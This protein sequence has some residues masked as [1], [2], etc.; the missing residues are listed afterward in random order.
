ML[1][2]SKSNVARSAIDGCATLSLSALFIFVFPVQIAFQDVVSEL[3]VRDDALRWT[4]YVLPSEDG[5][6]MAPT[7]TYA[8]VN[9][10]RSEGRLSLSGEGAAMRIA[11][12]AGE[13]SPVTEVTVGDR[14]RINRARKGDRLTTRLAGTGPGELA[15][16]SLRSMASLIVVD[17]GN[18]LP[19]VAFVKPAPLT[20][21]EPTTQ[22]AKADI[23]D[24]TPQQKPAR[25]DDKLYIARGVA[26]ASLSLV[27]AYAP[28]NSA[29]LNAPFNAL[30]GGKPK[31]GAGLGEQQDDAAAASD[32]GSSHGWVANTLPSS[33]VTNKEQKCLAEA[34]YF[35]ARG[36]PWKGQVAVAQV[37][38][39]R[40]KNPTYPASICGV[41]YQNKHRRNR[42][43]FSFAC[44]GIN[45]RIRNHA[46]WSQA[47]KIARE[48]TS[49]DHWLKVVGASTHYHATYV[50]PRWARHM[51]RL[52]RIG[53][54]IFYKT[55]YGGW[56]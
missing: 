1:E 16:G 17:G 22:V 15:A 40:V 6:K 45:D 9:P 2:F 27:H 5:T 51:I 37:V 21:K 23:K 8:N 24:A 30:F 20:D 18:D 47:Q 28:D 10:T 38:L 12:N 43:Q 54:H 49:G 36:E 46:L 34:I 32:G 35:E 29:D 39:N 25:V 13:V 4:A 55:K 50:R 52:G 44:D 26:A 19:R 3:K 33:V 7:Y 41:V 14:E 48:I 11:G 31:D 53:R 42:C 56:S